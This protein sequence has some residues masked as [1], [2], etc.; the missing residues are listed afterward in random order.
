MNTISCYPGLI[1]TA[2]DVLED[3]KAVTM[4]YGK[5]VVVVIGVFLLTDLEAPRD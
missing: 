4:I 2:A 3:S 5:A 1:T